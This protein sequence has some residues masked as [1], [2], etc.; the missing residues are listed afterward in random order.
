[1]LRY[2]EGFF[3]PLGKFEIDVA[4]GGG[5]Y[6]RDPVEACMGCNFSDLSKSME[7]LEE[8]CKCPRDMT[9]SEY[10]KLREKYK[11]L[12]EEDNSRKGFWK[13]VEENHKS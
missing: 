9:W 11:G 3:C 4:G 6:N 13:F 2:L 7:D 8:V 10:D 1:M 5:G 12:S